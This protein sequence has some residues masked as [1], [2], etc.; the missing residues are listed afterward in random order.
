[1]EVV[2][3][4]LKYLHN[5]ATTS[6]TTT[7]TTT[8]LPPTTGYWFHIIKQLYLNQGNTIIP[9]LNNGMIRAM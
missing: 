1:M 9:Y 7:T 5:L 2:I 6:T 8:L 3:V 4:T